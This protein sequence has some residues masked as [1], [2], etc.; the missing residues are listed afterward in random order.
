MK[1]VCFFDDGQEYYCYTGDGKIYR[2]K[3][4]EGFK[5][6]FKYLPALFLIL[7][8]VAECNS[9]V[10]EKI[11]MTV[12]LLLIFFGIAVSVSV[13]IAEYNKIAKQIDRTLTEAVLS[14]AQ[15]KLYIAQGKKRFQLQRLAI[16][17]MI[18]FSALLFA[19]FLSL[20]NLILWLLGVLSVG[21]TVVAVSWI[22]P[23]AKQRFFKT[24]G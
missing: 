1:Y 3:N 13:G 12:A 6:N 14:D 5:L 16:Y 11:N 21:L 9:L 17:T 20:N 2:G 23:F 18:I 7:I 15:F 22:Q 24:H 10:S 4:A 8:T 19:V